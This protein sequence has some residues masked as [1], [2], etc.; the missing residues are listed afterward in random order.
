MGIVKR[1]HEGKWQYGVSR[2]LPLNRLGMKRFR[3]WYEKRAIAQN[4]YDRLNGAIANGTINEVLPGLVGNEIR[5][6]TVSTFWEC[7]RDEYCKP[8]MSSWKRYQQSFK[9]ILEELGPVPLLEFRRHHLHSFLEKRIKKISRS[10]ANKDIAAIKKMFSYALEVGAVDQN[11]LT[12]FP[13]FKLQEIAMRLPTVDEFR[14]L[15]ETIEEP[16]IRALVA[17][18]GETGMRKNEALDLTWDRI[19]FRRR[20]IVIEKTKG[21]K[22][23]TL[24]LSEFAAEQLKQVL[25]FIPQPWVFCYQAGQWAGKRIRR[26]YRQLREAA[27]KIGL[28][29]IRFHTLRHFRATQWLHHGVD[30]RTVKDALGHSS[31]ATTVRYLKHIETHADKMLREALEKETLELQIEREREKSGTR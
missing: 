27:K 28:E 7:F 6:H 10:T 18:I 14:R 8:R 11:P 2:R 9:P 19:D 23:R 20:R 22:V 15:V 21:K 4:V 30:I 3:R 17:V 26:P 25:R 31:I 16:A 12:R 13:A 29:W 1:L 5:R 24:P